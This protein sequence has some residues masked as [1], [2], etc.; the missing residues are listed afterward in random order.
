MADMEATSRGFTKKDSPIMNAQ[1]TTFQLDTAELTTMLRVLQDADGELWFIAKEV[2]DALGLDVSNAA[3]GLD[4][5]E[6]KSV[7][8]TGFRGTG[9]RIISEAGFHTLAMRSNKP[10]AKLYRKWVTGKVLP[11]IRKHGAYVAGAEKLSPAAQAEFYQ[12]VQSQLNQ[13]I[14]RHDKL[15]EHDHWRNPA[16][17]QARSKQASEKIAAEMGLPLHLVESCASAGVA[18]TLASLTHQQP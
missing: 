12:I 13:A 15:T 17:Q 8:L 2:C 4:D 18:D 10:E 1:V 7:K 14:R 9:T 3:R 16:Q 6:I 11:S 5:D